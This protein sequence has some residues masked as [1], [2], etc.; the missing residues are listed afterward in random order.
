MREICV[1]AVTKE[2][3]AAICALLA[4]HVAVSIVGVSVTHATVNNSTSQEFIT[5]WV[6][7]FQNVVQISW[8]RKFRFCSKSQSRSKGIE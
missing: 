3:I 8:I 6:M 7:L 5:N 2:R 4:G 1:Q